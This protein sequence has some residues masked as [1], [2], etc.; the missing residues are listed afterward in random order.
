MDGV[1]D[2]G[3]RVGFGP[4]DVHEKDEPFHAPWEARMAAIVRAMSRVPTWTIDWFRHCRELIEPV[5]YLTRPYYDQWLQSYAAMMID[6]GVA[7]VEELSSGKSARAAPGM[8]APMR[9]GEV[10]A[11]KRKWQRFDRAVNAVPAF[12]IGDAVVAKRDGKPGHT[13]LP[14]YARGRRGRIEAHRGAHILPDTNMGGDGPAEALYSVS[15]AASELWPDV[16][17]SNDRVYVELWESYLE[18][19]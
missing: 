6:S 12:A 10:D 4:V 17:G 8:P 3:G 11:A 15:F 13:R 18:R 19:G 16:E 14:Q 5:D 1:H 2:L 7:T 9:P